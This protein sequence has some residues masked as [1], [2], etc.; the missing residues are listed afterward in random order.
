MFS[1]IFGKKKSSSSGFIQAAKYNKPRGGF[2]GGY[3]A[4]T[5]R[6][7][8]EAHSSAEDIVEEFG[9]DQEG[10]AYGDCWDRAYR[11]VKEEALEESLL[12]AILSFFKG[13]I[14]EIEIDYGR[15]EELAFDYAV[16]LADSWINGE[17]WIPREVIE[18]AYY[19]VSSHN[20]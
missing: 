7:I 11:E 17:T 1:S 5:F 6:N 2:T 18:W 13:G 4:W 19:D 16:E 14:E 10:A 20:G 15:V 9:L 12:M 8:I 3:G